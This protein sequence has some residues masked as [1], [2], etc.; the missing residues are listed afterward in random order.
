M[1]QQ[2][3]YCQME[4]REPRVILKDHGQE[5]HEIFFFSVLSEPLSLFYSLLWLTVF[6]KPMVMTPGCPVL[7]LSPDSFT[8][9]LRAALARTG[10]LSSGS[11][12]SPSRVPVQALGDVTCEVWARIWRWDDASWEKAEKFLKMGRLFVFSYKEEVQRHASL[13]AFIQLGNLSGFFF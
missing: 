7:A 9:S 10:P 1:V 13:M 8:F 11:N 3:I 5:L 4:N 12:P 6:T 2:G